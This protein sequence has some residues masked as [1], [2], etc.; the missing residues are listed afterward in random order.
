[1]YRTYKDTGDATYCQCLFFRRKKRQKKG[2]LYRNRLIDMTKNNIRKR[3]WEADAK[4]TIGHFEGDLV[5]S[6][7][8]S[9]YVLTLVDGCSAV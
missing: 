6:K 7:G 4:L 5:E 9:A 1:M 8:K 3:P 2:N